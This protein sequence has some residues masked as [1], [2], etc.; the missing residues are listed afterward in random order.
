MVFYVVL[1][2]DMEMGKVLLRSDKN[3][4]VSLES[5]TDRYESHLGKDK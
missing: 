1:S 3:V 5:R 2:E 4:T